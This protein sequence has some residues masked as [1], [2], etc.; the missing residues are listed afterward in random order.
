MRKVIFLIIIGLSLGIINLVFSQKTNSRK[1]GV[2][3]FVIKKA[4]LSFE[5][6]SIA[7]ERAIEMSSF[8]FIQKLEVAVPENCSYKAEVFVLFDSSYAEKLLSINKLT[9]PFALVNRILLFEDEDGVHVSL[10]NPTNINRT[11]LMD[12]E[13]YNDLSESNRISLRELI[14][15]AV[16]GE[17]VEKQYGQLRKK[18][19]IGRTM[20]IM[21]GGAFDGKIKDVEEIPNTGFSET[22]ER[23]QKSMSTPGQK[24][25]MKLAY[26]IVIENQKIAILGST[27]PRI[28]IKSFS[29]VK[30]GSDKSRKKFSC[31]G[32]AHAAAYPI[33]VVVAEEEG[34]VKVRLVNIMYRMKMYFED[35]GKWAFAKNMGMPG[36]I[37]DEL[38]VQIKNAFPER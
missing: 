3:E 13:K 31:P 17:K 38:E 12:D 6:A 2:Y 35:A 30:A 29:I 32:I 18:G 20:G 1:K 9:A 24:W 5:D 16:P 14:V 28:E 15:S 37:Q 21:A 26:T 23:L 19:Y 27:S 10:V 4:T 34:K 36:S 22:V 33:E 11:I 7:L 8:E 25:G